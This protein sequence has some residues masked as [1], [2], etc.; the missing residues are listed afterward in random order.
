VVY[1]GLWWG[2]LRERH[3]LGVPGVYRIILIWVF[4]EWDVETW[5]DRS[6]LLPGTCECGNEPSGSKKMREIS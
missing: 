2:N 3:H 5:T 1:I 6:G 4:G